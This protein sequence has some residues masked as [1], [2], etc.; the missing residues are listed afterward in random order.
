MKIEINPGIPKEE[1]SDDTEKEQTAK[2]EAELKNAQNKIEIMKSQQAD[3]LYM[4]MVKG[5]L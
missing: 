1:G 2:L 3:L 4:L 5:V